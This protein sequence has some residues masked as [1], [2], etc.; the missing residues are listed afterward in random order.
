M[1]CTDTFFRWHFPCSSKYTFLVT[2]L[3]LT[4]FRGQNKNLIIQHMQENS[5]VTGKVERRGPPETD[6]NSECK[7]Q[8]SE[9]Y[10]Q[11]GAAK[12]IT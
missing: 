12:K 4:I 8:L 11:V 6:R 5:I 1:C 9:P 10:E 7:G 2:V 3:S